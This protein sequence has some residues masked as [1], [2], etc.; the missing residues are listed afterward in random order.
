MTTIPD[1]PAAVVHPYFVDKSREVFRA[2]GGDPDVSGPLAAWAQSVREMNDA[3]LGVIV[4]DGGE[5]VAETYRSQSGPGDPG[6]TYVTS[7]TLPDGDRSFVNGGVMDLEKGL[8]MA[9]LRRLTGRDVLHVTWSQVCT[10]AGR[11]VQS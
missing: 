7:C 5:I 1:R 8:A 10:G 2:A 11:A 6:A 4:T 9:T 3:R